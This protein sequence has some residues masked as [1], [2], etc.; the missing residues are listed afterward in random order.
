MILNPYGPRDATREGLAR[1]IG[2]IPDHPVSLVCGVDY[3]MDY[4]SW[5]KL[6]RP[7]V[8]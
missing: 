5:E 4:L 7:L 8:P 2:Q 3:V 6:V 1:L